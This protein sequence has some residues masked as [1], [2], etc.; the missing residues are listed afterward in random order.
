M[1]KNFTRRFE[2]VV[3]TLE[4]IS[5][6]DMDKCYQVTQEMEETLKHNF[7]VMI[8]NDEVI[9]LFKSLEMKKSDI[10]RLI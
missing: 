7:E 3:E 10:E 8:S 2:K 4:D 6:W 5:S 1:E 9:K